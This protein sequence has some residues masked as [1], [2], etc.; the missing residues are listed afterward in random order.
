V[1]VAM[2]ALALGLGLGLGLGWAS[3]GANRMQGWGVAS[4]LVAV[5]AAALLRPTHSN[6]FLFIPF[7]PGF[8]NLP[9][10]GGDN[11]PEFSECARKVGWLQ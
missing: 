5:R 7:P 11:G 9:A 6:P 2:P 10:P 3:A 1:L 8:P 4:A